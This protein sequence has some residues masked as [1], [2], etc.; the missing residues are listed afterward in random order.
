MFIIVT[1]FIILE[2]DADKIRLVVAG[3]YRFILLNNWL[4]PNQWYHLCVLNDAQQNY[5]VT[6]YLDGKNISSYN[7]LHA[8]ESSRGNAIHVCFN[9]AEFFPE[10]KFY[11]KVT[12]VNSWSHVISS[13]FVKKISSCYAEYEGNYIRWSDPMWILREIQNYEK[14]DNVCSGQHVKRLHLFPAQTFKESQYLCEGLNGL[15]FYPET[16][17]DINKIY[18]WRKEKNIYQFCRM[19]W[20]SVWHPDREPDRPWIF[21]HNNSLPDVIPW[22]ADEPNGLH[23]ERCGGFDPEGIVDDACEANR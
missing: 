11:G 18:E 15:V 20:T 6:T 16:F 7:L 17:E 12:H 2:L 14:V 23:F 19:F 5:Q 9:D 1:N 8:F 3:E 21:H 13:E 22:A 10:M 4:Q